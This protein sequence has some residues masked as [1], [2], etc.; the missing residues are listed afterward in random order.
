MSRIKLEQDLNKSFLNINFNGFNT[1]I[2]A[3]QKIGL[4]LD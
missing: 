2:D 3:I 4:F 1:K